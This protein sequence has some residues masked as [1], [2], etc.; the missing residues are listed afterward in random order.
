MTRVLQ[1]GLFIVS[2]LTFIFVLTSVIKN[3]MNIHYAM[4]WIIWGIGTVLI[5]IFPEI[6]YFVTDILGIQMPVNAVFLI[7]IFLLYCMLFYAY[8][9]LSKHNDNIVDL[10]YEIAILKKRIEKL[11]KEGHHEE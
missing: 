4:A 11:E 1:I 8:L 10:N 9:K 5:S 6:I 7:M 2:F 3:K